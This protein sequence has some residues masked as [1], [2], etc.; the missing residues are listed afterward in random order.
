MSKNNPQNGESVRLDLF[1]NPE[2]SRGASR[3]TEL[4][5]VVISGLLVESWLPGSGWRRQ[6]LRAFG[7]QIG[8]GVVIK[9]RVRVKFPWRL[10]IGD[11]SWIGEGVWI[12]NLAMVTIGSQCC[13][14]QG[15][16]LCTGS[17]D[18]SDRT[19]RLITRPIELGDGCWMGAKTSL[20]PGTQVAPGA[21]LTMGSMAN[22]PIEAWTVHAGVPAKPVRQRKMLDS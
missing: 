20:A 22:G 9:P 16:Y 4:C 15:A 18:W 7:A 2:F 12:D 21:V 13:V 17:H 19:F 5:W 6:L 14:S 1:T 10:S 11:H 8:E 3:L